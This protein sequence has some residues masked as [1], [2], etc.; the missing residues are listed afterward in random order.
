MSEIGA[1]DHNKGLEE[2]DL[3]IKDDRSEKGHNGML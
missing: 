3:D 2:Q 1:Q